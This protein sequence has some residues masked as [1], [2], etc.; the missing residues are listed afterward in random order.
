MSTLRFDVD[1]I[2]KHINDIPQKGIYLFS[3]K[4]STLRLFFLDQLMR[5]NLKRNVSCMLMSNISILKENDVIK[6]SVPE[7]LTKDSFT[8]LEIPLYI[9]SFIHGSVDMNQCISDLKVYIDNINPALIV[10]Q[11]IELLVVENQQY[12]NTTLLSQFLNFLY[13]LKT[14]VVIDVSN[15][16][17][18]DIQICEKFTTGIFHFLHSESEHN[19]QLILKNFKNLKDDFTIIFSL[20]SANHIT[21]PSFRID[22]FISIHECKQVVLNRE[23]TNFEDI[24]TDLF[25]S[26]IEFLYYE[27]VPEINDLSIDHKFSLFL[28]LAHTKN[29]NGWAML[30]F[31]RKKYPFCKIIFLG[32]QETPAYQKVRAIRMGADKFLIYPLNIYQLKK[33]LNDIYYYEEE[34]HS[35]HLLH[36]ILFVSDSFISKEKPLML[37]KQTLFRFIKDFA[38]N[39]I[40]N[41]EI[42]HFFKFCTHKNSLNEI[43]EMIEFSKQ[44]MFI[45]S[46]FI[47]NKQILFFI[48][49]NLSKNEGNSI[50]TRLKKY[51]HGPLNKNPDDISNFIIG[52][53]S[54]DIQ[55]IIFPLEKTNIDSVL[56]WIYG[57][58]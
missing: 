56:E 22:E 13:S 35:N 9:N 51:S 6:I 37:Y 43:D 18:D 7:Y 33:S 16:D 28:V 20:D 41:G 15:F 36:K 19:H 57:G 48:Y 34:E 8:L 25:S 24:F 47:E 1:F 11:F 14:C 5:N 17:D 10:I 40:S 49:K 29:T 12:I 45:S 39:A 31:I 58:I 30:P 26:K 50:S 42:I 52:N 23:L 4:K 27:T 3:E 46:Y 38:F 55:K 44:V 54:D 2:D 53:N 21:T 32:T